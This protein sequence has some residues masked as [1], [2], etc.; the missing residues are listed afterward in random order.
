MSVQAVKKRQKEENT[1]AEKTEEKVVE[2]PKADIIRGRMPL[3]IVHMIKFAAEDATDG[4]LA[5]KFRTTNGK[6]SDIRKERNFGYIKEDYVPDADQ[7]AKAVA[8]AEQLEDTSVLKAVKKLK[9]ASDEQNAAF[10]ALRKGSRKSTPKV[11]AEDV[12]EQD[13]SELTE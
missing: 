10:E 1:M 5:T 8:F 4:A 3:P 6:V 12:P 7:I 2:T 13:L 9:P 11:A